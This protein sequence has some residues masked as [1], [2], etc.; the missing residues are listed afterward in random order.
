[1]YLHHTHK[2]ECNILSMLCPP[3]LPSCLQGTPQ[4]TLRNIRSKPIEWPPWLSKES[5]DFMRLALVRE[6]GAPDTGNA[7][8]H[9][10]QVL[11][12]V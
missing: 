8:C 2:E 5:L 10:V 11:P 4:E 1:M 12:A 3:S 9:D 7:G 6:K